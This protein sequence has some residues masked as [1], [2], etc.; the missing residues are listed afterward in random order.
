VW[1]ESALAAADRGERLRF[2][3]MA[4]AGFLRLVTHLRVFTEPTPLAHA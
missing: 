3:P 4:A 2:L 1:V